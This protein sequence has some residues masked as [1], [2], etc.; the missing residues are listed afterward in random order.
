MIFN[1]T[2]KILCYL[3]L[4]FFLACPITNAKNHREIRNEEDNLVIG[5]VDYNTLTLYTE[6]TSSSDSDNKDNRNI[7]IILQ[8]IAEVKIENNLYY[9]LTSLIFD[10]DRKIADVVAEHPDLDIEILN[11]VKKSRLLGISYPRRHS[12]TVNMALNLHQE[13]GLN[14]FSTLYKYSFRYNP[15]PLVTYFDAL[16][17][18]D[19]LV[20]DARGL[21]LN[22]AIFPSVYDED[23][24]MIYNVSFVN[25]SAIEERGLVKYL[26][27]AKDVDS[28]FKAPYSLVARSTRGYNKCDI[29]IANSDAMLIFA[30][31]G[32]QK[33]MKD[34]L[35]YVIVD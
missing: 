16:K 12:V 15:R 32:L 29:V 5:N 4:V 31:E 6:S 2:R 9:M 28:E 26:Y 13:K 17:N 23:G 14:I 25:Q 18:Y 30:N 1:N 20:I 24:N 21:N 7:Q 34:A 8:N 10:S 22:P 19:A 35:V 3:N 27:S 33:A 11:M